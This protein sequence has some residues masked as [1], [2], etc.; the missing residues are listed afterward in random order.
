LTRA[1]RGS[2]ANTVDFEDGVWAHRLIEDR[3]EG[4][5]P[6]GAKVPHHI[7][8]H[9][10]RMLRELERLNE[11]HPIDIVEAPIWDAEGLAAILCNRFCI[12]TSLHTPLRK[13]VETNPDWRANMTTAKREAYEEIEDRV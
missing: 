5:L 2:T 8:R 9:S 3:D 10:A 7:W 4:S 6:S 13:V 12:V 11:L 1:A